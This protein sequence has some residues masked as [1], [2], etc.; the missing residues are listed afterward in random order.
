MHVDGKEVHLGGK[1][2]PTT[3]RTQGVGG[4]CKRVRLRSEGRNLKTVEGEKNG[5]E[6]QGKLR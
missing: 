4:E 5:D 6:E 3:F 2:A 1:G